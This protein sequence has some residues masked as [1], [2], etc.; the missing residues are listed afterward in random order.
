[1]IAIGKIVSHSSQEEQACQTLESGVGV[2]GTIVSQETEGVEGNS[3]Y[4]GFFRK[5]WVKQGK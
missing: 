4:C 3:L 5:D 2:G 1:M